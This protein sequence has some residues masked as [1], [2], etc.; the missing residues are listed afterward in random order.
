MQCEAAVV[1]CRV[2]IRIAREAENTCYLG[3]PY[4]G[5]LGM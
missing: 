4:G 5:G 1:G 3:R 2:G